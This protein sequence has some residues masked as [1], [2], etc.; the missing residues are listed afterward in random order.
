MARFTRV[1]GHVLSSMM[2]FV[3]DCRKEPL[4]E[5]WNVRTRCKP[6][7]EACVEDVIT[8]FVKMNDR[9]I[10]KA[11][12]MGSAF[13]AKSNE[14]CMRQKMMAAL[15]KEERNGEQIPESEVRAL[16]EVLLDLVVSP[17]DKLVGDAAIM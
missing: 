10:K 11:E 3:E 7:E 4:P 6:D 2:E 16:Q 12:R 1:N 17:I 5:G 14:N 13:N 15:K 9:V 8:E